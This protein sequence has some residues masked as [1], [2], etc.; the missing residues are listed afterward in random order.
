MMSMKRPF[1]VVAENRRGAMLVLIVACLPLVLAFAA[2]AINIAYMQ[3]T[4]T[5]L[6]TA[7]DAAARAGSRTLSL[8]Q[9]VNQARARAIDAAARNT[10][11]GRSLT[12]RPSEVVFGTSALNATGQYDFTQQPDNSALLTGV[13]VLANRTA[14]SADGAIPL[15]FQ[16]MFDR[17]TFEPRRVTVASHI[18]RDVFLILDRSGSMRTRTPGGNRWNDLKK[19]VHK[20]M[21]TLNQ[22]PQSE[23]VG[24]ATYSTGATLDEQLSMN[25]NRILNRV[26]NTRVTGW[27]AI[28][29]GMRQ[30]INGLRNPSTARPVAAKTLVVMTDGRHNRGVRPD[31]VADEARAANITVHTITFSSGANQTLMRQVAQRGGGKH[32]HADDQGELIRVFEEVANNLPTLITQ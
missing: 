2:F 29:M 10:V 11:A 3:L 15:L 5:E 23:Q 12:I 21:Q 18:D 16:G 19:A 17:G 31:V 22:T 6:R 28:G 27:T 32:W 26:D 4:R 1:P 13:R 20:F 9:D 8:T 25:Y 7:S 14:A 24:L 30:G